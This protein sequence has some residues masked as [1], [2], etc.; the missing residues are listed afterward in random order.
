MFPTSVAHFHSPTVP[1]GQSDVRDLYMAT[2]HLLNMVP[3]IFRHSL[4]LTNR[5]MGNVLEANGTRQTV[6]VRCAY[7]RSQGA[8]CS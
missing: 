4:H 8:R 6:E 7:P 2:N 3:D 1:C 5:D